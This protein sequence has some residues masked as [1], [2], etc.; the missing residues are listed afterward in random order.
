MSFIK[1]PRKKKYSKVE[2]KKVCDNII[3]TSRSDPWSFSESKNDIIER[4]EAVRIRERFVIPVKKQNTFKLNEI[5]DGVSK[6]SMD[7]SRERKVSEESQ[8]LID[9]NGFPQLN[10]KE[11]EDVFRE[12]IIELQ[13]KQQQDKKPKN[14]CLTAKIV[15]FSWVSFKMGFKLSYFIVCSAGFL[16]LL[17]VLQCLSYRDKDIILF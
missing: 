11:E 17:R 5:K 12:L 1:P 7:E 3:L 16:Y 15:Y 2:D 9:F 14:A 13:H 10:E 8:P 4:H 6:V